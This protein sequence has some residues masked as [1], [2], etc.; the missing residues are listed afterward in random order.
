MIMSLAVV[1]N[2]VGAGVTIVYFV[3]NHSL[4]NRILTI[5]QDFVETGRLRG[6]PKIGNYHTIAF[7]YVKQYTLI[8]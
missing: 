4:I 8:G 6:N 2:I 5:P 7:S 3:L 1:D